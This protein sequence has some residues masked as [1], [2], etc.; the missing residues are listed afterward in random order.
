VSLSDAVQIE[1][2]GSNN[3][4]KSEFRTTPKVATI[5]KAK[6]VLSPYFNKSR[7][8][9]NQNSSVDISNPNSPQ[10]ASNSQKVTQ[11]NFKKRI[12]YLNTFNFL[13]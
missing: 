12:F 6:L 10:S 4:A 13:A 1:E 3:N 5:N 9:S 11:N 2:I 7:L 8:S